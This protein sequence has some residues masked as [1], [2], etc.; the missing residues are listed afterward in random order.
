MRS[1]W[2]QQMNNPLHSCIHFDSIAFHQIEFISFR[3]CPAFFLLLPLL[4]FASLHT[5]ALLV[6]QNWRMERKKRTQVN[7]KKIKTR[8]A[9]EW[10]DANYITHSALRFTFAPCFPSAAST[11]LK[12]HSGMQAFP[13]SFLNF[14][15]LHPL[16]FVH[17]RVHSMYSFPRQLHSQVKYLKSN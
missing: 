2:S 3:A 4:N 1:K 8:K 9:W 13:H 6:L 12:F 11:H 17:C 5:L 14:V 7:L 10:N 15:S 16:A